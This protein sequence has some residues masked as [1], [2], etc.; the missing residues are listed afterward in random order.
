MISSANAWRYYSEYSFHMYAWGILHRF[1]NQ[2]N[3]L[4][5]WAD[6]AREAG[7]GSTWEDMRKEDGSINFNAILRNVAYVF[8]GILGV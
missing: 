8:V 4:G 1:K 3:K 6:S 5:K 7:I 2:D